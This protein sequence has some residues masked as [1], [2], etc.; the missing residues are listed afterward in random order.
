[1]K[2]IT[3]IGEVHQILLGIAK[4]FDRICR[5]NNIRYMMLGGSMIG[6]IRHKGFIPWD[7]DMDFGVLREDY[8]KLKSLLLSDL[9]APYRLRSIDNTK[10]LVDDF[11]KIEDTRTMIKLRFWEENDDTIGINVDVFPLDYTTPSIGRFSRNNLIYHLVKIQD[12]RFFTGE[13]DSVSKKIIR[14]FIQVFLPFIGRK[15]ISTFITKILP[16]EGPCL[17]NIF[18]VYE[19][20]EVMPKEFFLPAKEYN[21][22]GTFF[23]GVNDYDRYLRNVYGDYM[24][25]PPEEKRHYHISNVFMK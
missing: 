19:L 23:M 17:M 9:Q 4:E 22:E 1:M 5:E 16:K 8:D 15:S 21:F 6:A 20:K 14:K 12:Y 11:F 24:K 3:G 10:S 25:L 13:L 2:E 7:D 18:G